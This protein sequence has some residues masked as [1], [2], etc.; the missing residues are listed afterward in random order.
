MIDKKIDVAVEW[1]KTH[2]GSYEALSKKVESIIKEV[3]DHEGINYHSVTSRPKTV[4]SF[5]KKALK[6]HY[7]NPLNEITDLAGVRV[8]TYFDSDA[9]KVS[10]TLSNLFETDP[11]HSIDKSEQLG[12][13]RVGYRSI[14]F[15]TK[16]SED[17]CKL[18]EYQRFEGM[19][20]E[21]QIRTILQHAWAEIEHD[22]NYKF[23]GVLPPEIQRRF[24]VLSGVLELADREFD[25]ISKSID[26]YSKDVAEK[27][28][29]GDLAI[30]INSTSL[31][32]Y[33]Q[34]KFSTLVELGMSPE[35]G[36]DDSGSIEIIEELKGYG[37]DS[38]E[39]LDKIV[40][41]DLIP[42]YKG[43]S[44]SSNFIALVRDILAINDSDL[45]FKKAWKRN[46]TTFDDD[47]KKIYG[48]YG[49]NT[50]EIEIKYFA[51]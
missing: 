18:P 15:V 4:D 20:F 14:H 11:E 47:T 44:G 6:K 46:W 49:I 38:L 45:Y 16:F 9:K 31:R 43:F 23:S 21:I 22:R 37:I 12:I 34:N 42:N 30:P 3:L 8:I 41:D 29:I 26:E 40:P 33:L 1:Y 48:K 25:S 7:E 10:N 24:K 28:N 19:Y 35:F 13:D 50:K 17:R 27:T 5:K 32:G 36:P 2:R 39:Q 51:K